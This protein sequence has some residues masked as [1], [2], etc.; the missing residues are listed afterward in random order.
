MTLEEKVHW[1][2]VEVAPNVTLLLLIILFYIMLFS[3]IIWTRAFFN[4][5]KRKR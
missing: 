4:K 3:S 5:G 1:I 2:S